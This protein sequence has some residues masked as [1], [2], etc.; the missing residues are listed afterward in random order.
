MVI[1]VDTMFYGGEGG[2]EA[3][4]VNVSATWNGRLS[5]TKLEPSPYSPLVPLP[6][7]LP[8]SVPYLNL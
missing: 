4:W 8:R 6:L 5:N 2:G 7:L 1:N 3:H